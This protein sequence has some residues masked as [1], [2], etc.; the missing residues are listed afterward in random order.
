M[1]KP[2]LPPLLSSSEDFLGI[3]SGFLSDSLSDDGSLLEDDSYCEK[4]P[5][6][7][8]LITILIFLSVFSFC[9]GLS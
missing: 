2:L 6:S 9:I 4:N 7:A 3:C 8:L 1:T 5:K